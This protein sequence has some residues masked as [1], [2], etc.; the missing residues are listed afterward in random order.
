VRV[1][2]VTT[3]KDRIAERFGVL[4]RAQ[5][6]AFVPFTVLGYPSIDKSIDI[7][8][9]MIDGGA[10]ALEL[11]LAFSDPMADGPIIEEA[12][13]QTLEKGCT[14][15]DALAIIERIREKNSDV[16]ITVMT[17]YNP[18]LARGVDKFL[19]DLQKAGVDG[20]TIVDLPVEEGSDV[21]SATIRYGIAPIMLVSPLTTKERLTSILGYA[22][23]YIYMIS[24]VG[25][26]G[27]EDR[28]EET[29]S[30]T[31]AQLKSASELPICV[32]FGISE[33]SHANKMI[34]LGADGV[35]V[36]SKVVSLIEKAAGSTEE[37]F[38]IRKRNGEGHSRTVNG[39]PKRRNGI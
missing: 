31:V 23:G 29:L 5:Q 25:I 18:V 24:R 19:S 17:Y 35:I 22:R 32:G 13:R 12:A 7:I 10:D 36:G 34:A 28:F 3:K 37:V 4:A 8:Q 15:S 20:L 14:V 30:A 16:P 26:T 6:R 27:L 2:Q 1:S 39:V 33:L 11:G 38:D 9:A 21:Y